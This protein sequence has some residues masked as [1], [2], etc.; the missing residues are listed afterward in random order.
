VVPA[1]VNQAS[2]LTSDDSSKANETLN[3]KAVD[4]LDLAALAEDALQPALDFA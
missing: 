3:A 2:T 1:T 4:Q